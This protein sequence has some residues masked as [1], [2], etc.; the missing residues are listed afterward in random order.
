MGSGQIQFVAKSLTRIAAQA[1]KASLTE[2]G[3][4]RTLMMGAALQRNGRML[5]LNAKMSWK[6]LILSRNTIFQDS[7][8]TLSDCKTTS[9]DW[10]MTSKNTK[11]VK[12][13]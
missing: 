6:T 7:K 10:E 2:T 3:N 5:V 8:T 12:S 11:I 13:G 1:G 4:L 9:S